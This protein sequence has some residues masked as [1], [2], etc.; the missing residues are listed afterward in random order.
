MSSQNCQGI[1]FLE[2]H[3]IDPI[4]HTAS[5]FDKSPFRPIT[6]DK[7]VFDTLENVV[8]LEKCEECGNEVSTAATSCPRC[9][10]IRKKSGGAIWKISVGIFAL[11]VFAAVFSQNNNST[12]QANANTTA[13]AGPAAADLSVNS[14]HREGEPVLVGYTGYGVWSS[15]WSPQLTADKFLDQAPNAKYLFVALTVLNNDTKARDI[16][17]LKLV[18]DQGAEYDADSRGYL[19]PGSLGLIESLN[20]SVHKL[21]FIV[22]DVPP[23]KNYR[24]EL[25][26]GFWSKESAF[27]KLEPAPSMPKD[28]FEKLERLIAKRDTS[29]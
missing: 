12:T 8:A 19:L 20:P 4:G 6:I 15:W 22:F 23:D 9:G 14:V 7:E 26:G 24:L 11:I 5:A 16:P 18:D 25:S 27:V 1:Y 13:S 28:P 17:P 10:Y 29:K 2:T 3:L 21:G